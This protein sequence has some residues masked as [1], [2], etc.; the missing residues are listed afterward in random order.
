MKIFD[1]FMFFDENVILDVRLNILN[2]FVDY[3]VIVESRY[4]HNGHEK[5]LNFDINKYKNFKDKIIYII[6]ENVPKEIKRINNHDSDHEKNAK[7]IFNAAF[8]E[9][10]QRNSII[11]GLNKAG[12]DDIIL[13]S[14]VDEIPNLKNVRF[15]EIKE[16][17]IF[18][19]Q[20]MFYYKFNLKL[21]NLNWI[22]TKSCKKKYLKTPQWLRNIK[23]R[24]YPF[25]RLDTFFSDNKYSD[26]KF[27]SDGGWHFTNIKTAEQI[28]YKLKSYLHHREFEV[29]PIP[30]DEINRLITDKKAIYNL[31]LDKRDQKIG[32]GNKL[33]KYD[34]DKLPNYI[35]ENLNKYKDW[36]D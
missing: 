23:D 11:N 20:E 18:F 35:R 26:I 10:D 21:P 25:Y 14:D 6:H 9:N 17:L 24:K 19:K 5:D 28:R 8:R 13:I 36:I 7:Y 2:Q 30:L 29:K 27:V 12:E 32:S 16:K 3:F 33:E 34:I 31:K 4:N 15:Q 22:G 1:C